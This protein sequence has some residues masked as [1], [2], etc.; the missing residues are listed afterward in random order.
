MPESVAPGLKMQDASERR[1][2]AMKESFGQRVKRLREE[3]GLEQQHLAQAVG[4]TQGTI[5]RIEGGRNKTSRLLMRL[6][7]ALG[8]SPEY[9]ASGQGERSGAKLTLVPQP[10]SIPVMP[11]SKKRTAQGA[12]TPIEQITLSRGWVKA[13]LPLLSSPAHL[14]VTT[15][16]GNAMSPTIDNGDLLLV[17]TGVTTL[18]PDAVLLLSTDGDVSCRRAQRRYDDGWTVRADNPVYEP[19]HLEREADL[20]GRIIGRVLYRLRGLML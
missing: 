20:R 7:P 19:Q 12:G 8:V 9:L 14:R 17:D 10:E 1:E 3:L 11:L 6:A 18:Q 13:N 4:C 15:M 2:G 16:F 5:S